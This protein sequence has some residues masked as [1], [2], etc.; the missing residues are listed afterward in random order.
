MDLMSLTDL[1]IG[2]EFGVGS[3]MRSHKPLVVQSGPG[4]T[5]S[6]LNQLPFLGLWTPKVETIKIL[7]ATTE[8]HPILDRELI[9]DY[10]KQTLFI[11]EMY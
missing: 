3:D 1:A 7:W 9:I 10:L 6:K 2:Y 5:D 11:M 4:K 8:T